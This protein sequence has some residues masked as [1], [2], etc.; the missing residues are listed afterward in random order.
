MAIRRKT[1]AGVCAGVLTAGFGGEGSH[2]NRKSVPSPQNFHLLKCVFPLLFSLLNRFA[3]V[4][5]GPKQQMEANEL[6]VGTENHNAK[7]AK[8]ARS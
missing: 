8:G 5:Q 3:H 6:L 4:F 2:R 1:A 7:A